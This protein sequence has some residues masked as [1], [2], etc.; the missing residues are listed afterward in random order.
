[1]FGLFGVALVPDIPV[2][3]SISIYKVLFPRFVLQVLFLFKVLSKVFIYGLFKD[4]RLFS[5]SFGFGFG[6]FGVALV[7][8]I[9]VGCR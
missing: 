9:P 2:G 7:P 6:L 8:D 1:V 4:V 3:R 5:F